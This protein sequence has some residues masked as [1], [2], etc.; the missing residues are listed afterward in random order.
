MLIHKDTIHFND[1]PWS[2]CGYVY[3]DD[4]RYSFLV[5]EAL[6]FSKTGAA[7]LTP[8]DMIAWVNQEKLQI[9]KYCINHAA[10]RQAARR[11]LKDDDQIII[12]DV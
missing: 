7:T 12:I 6:I 4:I 10:K 8:S 9:E 11:P 3:D 2:V 1:R 5:P